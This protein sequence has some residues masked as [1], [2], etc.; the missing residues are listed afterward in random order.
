MATENI[1]EKVKRYRYLLLNFVG[2]ILNLGGLGHL[3]VTEIKEMRSQE[4]A[5]HQ[6]QELADWS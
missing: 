2:E 1:Y 4:A 6:R 5:L 3:L